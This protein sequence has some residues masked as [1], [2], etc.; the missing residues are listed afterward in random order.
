MKQKYLFG[1]PSWVLS[2]A[3]AILSFI[4]LSVFAGVL[5][6]VIGIDKNIS[7]GI[8]YIIYGLI[9]GLACFFICKSDPKSI[10]YVPLLCNL[11]GIIAAT[12]EPGFW[13]TPLWI[14]ISSSWVLSLIGSIFGTIAGKRTAIKNI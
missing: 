7:E 14:Y 3:A 6:S 12:V 9:V 5:N 2:I 1:F 10:W 11:G 8:S 4:V 13:I